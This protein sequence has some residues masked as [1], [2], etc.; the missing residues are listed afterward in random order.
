[1]L[2]VTLHGLRAHWLR[3]TLTA[4]TI[5]L[6]VALVTGTLA[7]TSS[8]QHAITAATSAPPGLIV[9]QPA[10]PAGGKPAGPPV[11]LAAHLVGRIRDVGGVAASQ[12]LITATKLTIVGPD[13][14]PVRHARAVNELLTYPDIPALAA[15]YTILAGGPP[16]KAGQALLDAAT[17]R[18][19][20][21]HTGQ[22]FGVLTPA[23]LRY[24][25]ITGITGFHGLDSPPADQAASFDTPTVLVTSG[26]TAQ[27]LAGYTGQFT[28]IDVLARPGTQV[29]ALV[30]RLD[31]LLPA[32]VIAISGQQAESQAAADAT[33][34]VASLRRYLLALAAM[35]LLVGAFIIGDT[36]AL[37]AAQRGREYALLR[38]TGATCGQVLRSALAEA[39]A[40]GGVASAAGLAIGGVASM[41]L[42][43]VISLLGGTLPA[44]G[45]GLS[46]A[47]AAAGMLAGIAVTMA[48]ALRAARRAAAVPPVQALRES[49]ADGPPR[50]AQASILLAASAVLLAAGFTVQAG[51]SVALAAA[52]SLG[53]VA[54]LVIAAPVIGGWAGRM[55]G[56]CTSSPAAQLAGDTTAARASRTAAATAILTVGLAA[57]AAVGVMSASATAAAAGAVDAGSRADYYL[58]GST[59]PQL[60]ARIAALPGVSAVTRLD[61]PLAT[62]AGVPARVAGVD[63]ATAGHLLKLGV[64]QGTLAALHGN[65]VLVSAPLAARHGWHQ[66]SRVSAD[67][68]TGPLR[69]I[70]AGTFPASQFLAAGYLMPITALFRAM[71]DQVGQ[72]SLLLIKAAPARQ[73]AVRASI[74]QL[75]E[76]DP[77]LTLQ[78]RAQYQAARAADL[79]AFSHPGTLFTVLAGLT[80]LIAALG[81]A[82]ALA[83]ASAERT[84]EFGMLRALGL[85]RGELAGMI[86]AEALIMCLAGAVPGTIA[87]TAA[88]AAL[89]AGL[90]RSQDGIAAIALP[91]G[92]LGIALAAACAIALAASLIPGRRAGR[93]TPVQAISD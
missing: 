48:S 33:G 71:P 69:M 84:T 64:A 62:V 73:A 56:A 55:L 29:P 2:R 75:I 3:L 38:A 40:V 18:A 37:L 54:S 66:G 92:Q 11:T 90:I 15:Q 60:A 8:V 93:V 28:Q 88:G 25:T 67:F 46:P 77:Q 72:A 30:R 68:G 82:N 17:A 36:F 50:G 70:V 52:G 32:G 35:A 87:G 19:L 58:T 34:Y 61:T 4:V 63:P 31:R 44:A 12:G 59:G 22:R 83:L 41:A 79:G 91:P 51:P 39:A 1:M 65:Q 24:V 26:P 86:S 9:V 5:A 85:T 21:C 20:H 42:R 76:A 57:T 6:G 43:S 7:L 16:A 53:M 27:Q 74:S 23:G 78:T 80:E 49:Q 47:G 10:N 45:L 14:R 89:S 81:I 13:G